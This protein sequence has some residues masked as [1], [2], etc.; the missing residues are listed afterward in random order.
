MLVTPGALNASFC[1]P[2]RLNL[3][4]NILPKRG[5]VQFV[6]VLLKDQLCLDPFLVRLYCP[7]LLSVRPGCLHRLILLGYTIQHRL[8]QQTLQ[9]IQRAGLQRLIG[10]SQG[11]AVIGLFFQP[12]ISRAL[13]GPVQ[14]DRHLKEVT[15]SLRWR[16]A[17]QL[18]YF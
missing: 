13:A 4:V 10:G 2:V 17:A 6:H 1:M 18:P 3:R 8:V 11:R 5:I 15:V 14:P 12:G 16:F 9:L 7:S